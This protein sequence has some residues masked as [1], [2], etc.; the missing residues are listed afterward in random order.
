M[1]GWIIILAFVFMVALAGFI[2]GLYLR[3][4]NRSTP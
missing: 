1:T 3:R 4:R 2:F